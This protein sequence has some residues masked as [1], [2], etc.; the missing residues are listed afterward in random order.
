MVDNDI[1]TSSYVTIVNYCEPSLIEFIQEMITMSDE[2]K[3][4][5]PN[6]PTIQRRV[7]IGH[8]T[9][10]QLIQ[11]LNDHSVMMNAYAN[12]I[13]TD[14]KF[15]TSDIA[16]SVNT[17]ELT[18]RDI[19]FPEGANIIQIYKRAE[20]V[21]LYLCPLETG[22][23]LRLQY[24]DQEEGYIGK[25]SF[26]HQ[27]PY[28]SITI[29]SKKLYEDDDF[30]KGFYLRKID[31]VLWLRGYICGYDNVWTPDDHFIFLQNKTDI[32]NE[33]GN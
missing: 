19:G 27:A 5:Y 7:E 8:F 33:A 12:R 21:G 1:I 11:K 17:V 30:P 22:P 28:G 32:L 4:K 14:D 24:L 2:N 29:A 31:G 3:E 13:F 9:K 18:V 15:T 26:Q 6:C 10:L 20:E 25:P 16:Y 23:Y